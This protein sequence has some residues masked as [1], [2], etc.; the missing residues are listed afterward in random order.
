MSCLKSIPRIR[1]VLLLGED[2]GVLRSNFG[3]NGIFLESR[4]RN[5]QAHASNFIVRPKRGV[6]GMAF[7]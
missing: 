7:G 6:L 5:F 3:T 2:L 4:M 1:F